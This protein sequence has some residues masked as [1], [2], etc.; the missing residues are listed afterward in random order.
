MQHNRGHY[1]CQEENEPLQLLKFTS[2]ITEHTDT[3][4]NIKQISFLKL[5]LFR[6]NN[7]R[8]IEDPIIDIIKF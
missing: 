4:E 7:R 1:L 3:F 2:E 8:L 6:T 5:R